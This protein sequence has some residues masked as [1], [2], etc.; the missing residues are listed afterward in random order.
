VLLA[1]NHLLETKLPAE[2]MEKIAATIGSDI[3]FFI[4]CR[5]AICR[6]R[7][8]IL[9]TVEGVSVADILL[10][11][12][13]FR[14]PQPGPTKLGQRP[15]KPFATFEQFHGSISLMNNLEAPVF[16]KYLL[17]PVLKDAYAHIL[18]SQLP[19]CPAQVPRFSPCFAM[20]P[21]GSRNGFL[22]FGPSFQTL[23][24]RIAQQHGHVFS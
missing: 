16:S 3:P 7:G 20:E 21:R 24:S 5:P 13:P 12:P 9:E 17:L 23:R 18:A 8:E 10:V 2:E 1:L 4:R 6:G 14:F 22:K 19:S 11:K 15:E